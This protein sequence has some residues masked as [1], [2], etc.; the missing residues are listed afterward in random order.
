MFYA[1]TIFR[2]RISDVK[3]NQVIIDYWAF[4]KKTDRDQ[5]VM[6]NPSYFATQKKDIPD[7]ATIRKFKQFR[8]S[9]SGIFLF[10]ED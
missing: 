3:S 8:Q 2:G 4:E 10:P 6:C 9:F 7:G 5:L 1:N